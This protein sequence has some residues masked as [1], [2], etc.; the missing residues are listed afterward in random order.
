MWAP[1]IKFARACVRN[2]H[3]IAAFIVFIAP[4]NFA[5]TVGVNP[6][7]APLTRSRIES[8]PAKQ[9]RE[10]LAYLQRSEKQCQADKD[11]LRAE[12]KKAGL[13]DPIKPSESFSARSIPLNRPVAWYA[14]PEARHIADVILS[15]QTPA[16][17]WSKNLDMSREPRR[18]GEAYA[19]NDLSH[20]LATNDFDIPSDAGWNYVGTI[21]NDA[22]TTQ[23]KYLGKIV[24][25]LGTSNGASYRAAFQR[26]IDY[27]LAAQYPN[28]G[29]PQVWP[30]QGGYHDAITFNDDAMVQVMELLHHVA[31]GDGDFSFVTPATRKR[32]A[33]SFARAI[34]CALATQIVV[35]GRRTIWPQQ[36][37]AL[38]LQP[39]SARNFE[40]PAATPPESTRLL[41]M[42]MD[43]PNPSLAEQ[44]AVRAAVAW[45]RKT[46]IYGQRWGATPHGRGL[47]ADPNSGPLWARYYQIGTDKP[48]F[49]DRDKSIH[50]TVDEISLER[51]N[52]YRWYSSDPQ[53]ALDRFAQWF[54]QHPETQ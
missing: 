47:T 11:A 49:G 13:A 1:L 29:W 39:T 52:G 18:P 33:E 27:L 22:T 28:G 24:S 50:D 17:G 36:S 6:P 41:L 34:Q 12:L 14:G 44:Q 3:C 7:A 31:N 10:W 38:T 15:F 4:P 46:A 8:L 45:L 26:G 20:F 42:L 35:N 32:A 40:P 5:A 25:S 21:D 2:A 53:Q 9:K 19:A 51:R 43:I 16:G 23:L 37:D 54:K 30:L 48:I